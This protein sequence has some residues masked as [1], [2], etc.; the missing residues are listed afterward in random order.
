MG[1]DGKQ[2]H[3]QPA[4]AAIKLTNEIKTNAYCR[5]YKIVLRVSDKTIY[6]AGDQEKW[7]A[8]NRL[9]ISHGMRLWWGAKQPMPNQAERK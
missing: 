5:K 4:H 1:M 9:Y 7:Y 3:P 2:L 6:R 8:K